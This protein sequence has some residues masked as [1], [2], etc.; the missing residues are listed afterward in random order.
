MLRRERGALPNLMVL[1]GVLGM[2]FLVVPIL[3]IF[4]LSIDT[5]PMLRF[6]PRGF[7]LRWYEEYLTSEG[8]LDATFLSL[9]IAFLASLIATL[10]G[11]LAAIGM[12][13]TRVP[14]NKVLSVVLITPIL[15]PLV[16]VAIAVYNVYAALGL[17]GTEIGIALAHSVLAIPFV[18]LNV[19][20]ALQ[21]V[22]RSY[23][24]AALSLGATPL[25]AVRI[26]TVPLIWRGVAAGAVFAFVISFDEVVIA[27]FLSSVS[28]STLPKKMLDGIFF[29]LSPVLAAIS[30]ILVLFN[31]ALAVLGLAL[32]NAAKRATA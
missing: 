16:V 11:T 21:A 26:V 22:P 23:E 32:A 8:W 14:G 9:R 3:V 18:L 12:N 31:I 5:S 29:D 24:E 2:I 7:T 28:T 20:A 30:S 13:R 17:I 6:P 19:N 15:L 4:P 25:A 27:M 10:A 1:V